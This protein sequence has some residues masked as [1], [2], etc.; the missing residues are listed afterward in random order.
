M[1]KKTWMFVVSLLGMSVSAA[2]LISLIPPLFH[3]GEQGSVWAVGM[4][5]CLTVVCAA[6]ARF[7][8]PSTPTSHGG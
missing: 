2:V 7:L 1:M 8:R 6:G 5:A 4:L 3:S